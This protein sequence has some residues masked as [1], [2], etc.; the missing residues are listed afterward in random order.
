[1]TM[2]SYW[3][4]LPLSMVL[5]MGAGLPVVASRVAGI[6]EVVKDGVSGLLVDAGDSNQLARALGTLVK[7]GQLRSQ[8]GAA[9]RAFVLPRFGI[10]GY[11]DSIVT[12]YDRLL[13]AKGL[14]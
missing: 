1:F 6:P 8:L 3:E 14:N 10:N 4:G 12:L 13:A 9:A 7:D 11:V 5:A 2:P